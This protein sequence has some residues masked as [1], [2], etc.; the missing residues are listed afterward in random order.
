[1]Q[2]Q[3]EG[4]HQL[5]WKNEWYFQCI[6]CNWEKPISELDPVGFL[7]EKCND[8]LQIVMKEKFPKRE[9][10]FPKDVQI[11]VWKYSRAL[12]VK[13]KVSLGEG[14]MTVALARAM[15]S[16][17][18]ILVCASTGNTSASLAAY[19]ASAGLKSAVL[20]P[21]GKVAR[22]KLVQALAYGAKIVKVRGSFDTALEMVEELVSN[23]K[24]FYLMNSINPFRVEGQKTAAY[25]IY[26]QLGR[27]PD[28]VVLPVGNAGNISAIWKGFKE[29]REW[30]I[31]EKLPRM[32]G[33][34]AEG[35]APIAEALQK[36][37]DRPRVWKEPETKA[38]AIRIGNPVSWKKAM[39]AIRESKGFALTVSDAE[40]L[41][42]R[43]RLAASEGIF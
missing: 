27:V 11:S 8:L 17:A 30:G 26:E 37:Y 34:Q 15:D 19:A 13:K 41:E 10:L 22:G 20:V 1:M 31:T 29:L 40:I 2:L 32:V 36:G 7:C 25:E 16:N 4:E 21:E 38:S 33:V 12:P 24:N 3:P 42:S 9:E 43:K 39:N 28:Y 6:S 23:D 18:K 14:G 35:A 5:S